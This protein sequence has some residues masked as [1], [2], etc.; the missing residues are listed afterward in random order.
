MKKLL[1][2]AFI[3]LLCWSHVAYAQQNA[4]EIFQNFTTS[5]QRNNVSIGTSASSAALLSVNPTQQDMMVVNNGS[6]G[7]QLAIGTSG[8]I[9]VPTASAGGTTQTYIPA[10]AVILM[11]RNYNN[12]FSA[13]TDSG[14]GSL[15]IHVGAGD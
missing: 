2:T 5:V 15:I 8:V 6:V 3:F 11:S 10:G 1:T 13:I 4:A 14:T 9:A 7:V 12:Y